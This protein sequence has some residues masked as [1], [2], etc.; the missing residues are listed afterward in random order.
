MKPGKI[1]IKDI[2]RHLN[3]ST[4]T[5]SRAMRGMHDIHPDTRKAVLDLAKEWDY[6]PNLM[7]LNLVKSKTKTLGVIVPNLNYYYFSEVLSRIEDAA[8]AKGYSVLIG[9]SKESFEREKKNVE[10]LMHGQVDG[11][12]ISLSRDT[13]DVEHLQHLQRRGI[14]LVFFD[15][16]TD[17]IEAPAVIVDNSKAAHK[18]VCHLIE[19]GYKRIAYMAGPPNL[20]I[21]NQRLTGYKDALSEAGLDFH[22]HYVL[23]NDYMPETTRA[24]VLSLLQLPAPPDAILCV[25]DRI[26]FTTIHQ[27][28]VSG[29]KVPEDIGIVSFNDDPMCALFTPSLTSVAQPIEDIGNQTVQLLIRQ[30]KLQQTGEGLPSELVVLPTQLMIRESSR[31][32]L[33]M[34]N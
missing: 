33:P 1:T 2:A 7:A 19:N 6:Q 24:N 9:Q 30:I 8:H 25:S 23:H 18:G 4:A 11:L 14:P 12:I 16:H 26:A 21:S 20:L 5:V 28:K 32:R 29:R 17:L 13:V 3:I 22:E 10:D 15:R 27:I 34:G 31:R